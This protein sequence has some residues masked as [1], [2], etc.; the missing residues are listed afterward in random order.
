MNIHPYKDI[1]RNSLVPRREA[2]LHIAETLKAIEQGSLSDLITAWNFRPLTLAETKS[3]ALQ[4]AGQN[5]EIICFLVEKHPD[6]IKE[7]AVKQLALSALP[8]TSPL[9][10]F[11]RRG[12]LGFND[13]PACLKKALEKNNQEII[14]A[15]TQDPFAEITAT[16]TLNIAIHNHDSRVVSLFLKQK[17]L[18][19]LLSKHNKWQMI[20]EKT[21][22]SAPSR[23]GSVEEHTATQEILLNL[24]ETGKVKPTYNDLHFAIKK[25][26]TQMEACLRKNSGLQLTSAID[27]KREA[28]VI[29]ILEAGTVDF[30]T[31]VKALRFAL[32]PG[33]KSP[34]IAVKLWNHL[35]GKLNFFEKQI[36]FDSACKFNSSGVDSIVISNLKDPA[37]VFTEYEFDSLIQWAGSINGA[38]K[39]LNQCGRQIA[40]K[41]FINACC[42]ARSK[43]CLDLD[44]Y[45]WQQWLFNDT[46]MLR[47]K[48]EQIGDEIGSDES[49][50]KFAIACSEYLQEKYGIDVDV[51]AMP[52][53]EPLLNYALGY[54]AHLQEK[55]Q[56]DMASTFLKNTATRAQD[57]G[58]IRPQML[59]ELPAFDLVTDVAIDH[60]SSLLMP[61]LIQAVMRP[62]GSGGGKI[63]TQNW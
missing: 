55:F 26:Y 38:V 30:D 12:Y 33:D 48:L 21:V 63:S 46:D 56:I 61:R 14:N 19:E 10:P 28:E 24:L 13:L 45:K 25:R 59:S 1:V 54:A 44:K 5:P 17:P 43:F 42:N 22:E 11:L 27:N 35:E 40:S 52:S 39:W 47:E 32:S 23:F 2:I 50:N 15:I 51:N 41:D 62:G 7:N 16:Q 34:A 3:H 29:Q 36:S 4:L 31:Q 6:L 60:V 9:L 53:A 49:I 58:W 18:C 8:G 57:N 37:V 20:Y